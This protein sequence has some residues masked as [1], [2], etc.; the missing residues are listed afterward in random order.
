[1]SANPPFT[2]AQ[3]N[4][5]LRIVQAAFGLHMIVV[6]F[7]AER[8]RKPGT[9]YP[10]EFEIPFILVGVG[11]GVAFFFF[12]SRLPHAESLIHAN[13]EDR[14]ALG[15]RQ[16]LHIILFAISEALVLFGFVTRF[17]GASVPYAAPFYAAG[18]LFLLLSSPR[19]LD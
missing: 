7:M 15:K 18:I 16:Q 17:M 12:R 3:S 14:V 9:E 1:M 11:L 13:L 5:I 2:L 19:K 6:I 8:I 4:R 10:R